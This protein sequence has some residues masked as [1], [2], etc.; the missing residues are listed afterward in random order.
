M[1]IFW[2]SQ[3]SNVTPPVCLAA[4]TGAAIAESPPMKTGFAAWKVA[5]GL[6][7]VPLLFA[8]T[9]FLS[10]DWPQMLYIFFFAMFGLWAV[11]AAIEGYWENR[12]N[13]VERLAT[14]AVGAALMWPAPHW[15]NFTAFAGF[16][17]LFAWNLRKPAPTGQSAGPRASRQ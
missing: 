15:V 5:K 3:D 2:L 17:V 6:Y 11:A 4:F 1:I 8:Y 7:F 10:G 12:M 9:P 13:L 14:L 16:V